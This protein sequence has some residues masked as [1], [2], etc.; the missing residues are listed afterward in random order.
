M[1]HGSGIRVYGQEPRGEAAAEGSRALHRILRID[2]RTRTPLQQENARSRS[3]SRRNVR[4]SPPLPAALVV[5]G[6][7]AERA[8]YAAWLGAHGHRAVEASSSAEA[9]THPEWGTF[10]FTVADLRSPNI[11]GVHLV[12]CLRSVDPEAVVLIL[13][14]SSDPLHT[15]LAAARAGPTDLLIR[16][17][18]E[19]SICR[20]MPGSVQPTTAADRGIDPRRLYD[21]SRLVGTSPQLLAV[22]TLAGKVAPHNTPVLI[23]GE[24]GTGKELLARAIH[25][26]SLRAGR[27]MVCINC[28]AIPELLLESELFG[29]RRGAFTGAI[30]DKPGLLTT[31]DGGT[32]FLDEIAELPPA[33]QA[34]LLR[35]LQD[36]TYFPVGGVQPLHADVRLIAAT[37]APLLKRIASREFRRDLY[38][39]LAAF[40]IH[41]P[42]LCERS[43]DISPLAHHFLVELSA[44]VGK[45]VPGL[46]REAVGYL[47]SQRWHGNARELRNA[48]ERAIIVST[49]GLLTS[50]DFRRPEAQVTSEDPTAPPWELP[51][52]GIDLGE[53]TRTL[54]LAALRRSGYNISAAARLLHITRPALRHRIEKYDL[55]REVLGG[56]KRRG[57]GHARTFSTGDARGD[58]TTAAVDGENEPFGSSPIPLLPVAG[59]G[60]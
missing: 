48:I 11:D 16:P 12:Q 39:R 41:I 5:C 6:D 36:G 22:L 13:L 23:T 54:I 56:G 42:P 58:G 53:L 15:V 28:A 9:L 34:K 60:R 52:G 26:N 19:A 14:R 32:L 3:G 30:A 40:P 18:D 55:K 24:S 33:T 1:T 44:E 17:V 21:F 45:K 31:A 57:P 25:A 7:R 46:S 47:M 59:K 8:T 43:D 50:L 4:A 35:F 27:S 37:N 29:Y 20:Y 2:S 38:Y 51:P 49:G 10:A